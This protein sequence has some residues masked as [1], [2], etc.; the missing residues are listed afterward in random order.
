[1]REAGSQNGLGAACLPQ[2]P[3]ILSPAREEP[4]GAQEADLWLPHNQNGL[5]LLA[6]SRAS[7]PNFWTSLLSA[8]KLPRD[9]PGPLMCSGPVVSRFQDFTSQSLGFLL[10]TGTFTT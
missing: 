1:M 6:P 10:G 9:L 7:T 8:L 2:S 3:P 5:S 4:G